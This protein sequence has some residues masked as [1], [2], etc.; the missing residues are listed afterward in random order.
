MN[1]ETIL[2]ENHPQILDDATRIYNCD[3]TGF[4]LSPKPGKVIAYK[5]DRH[6]NQAGTSSK[7][8]HITMLICCTASGHYVPPLVVYPGVQPRVELRE[9]FHTAFPQALFGNSK[10]GWMDTHLFQEYLENGF[11]KALADRHVQRPVL[12]LIDG[13]RCHLSIKA[14]KYCDQNG[15]YLYTLYPNATH[16]LQPLDLSLMGSLKMNYRS[17]MKKWYTK[18]IGAIFNKYE[19]IEVFHPT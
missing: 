15:I 17:E 3:E 6:I 2:D 1:S 10:S 4:P 19:F 16:L 13:A 9:K 14:S 7:K 11:N 5:S 8:T 12:L 18:Y